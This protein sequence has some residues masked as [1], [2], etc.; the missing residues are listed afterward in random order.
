M[1]EN[2]RVVKKIVAVFDQIKLE[3]KPYYFNIKGRKL[4]VLPDVFS[5]RHFVDSKLFPIEIPKIVKNKSF[6]EIGTG[7]GI[8]ALLCAKNGAKVVATDINPEAIKNCKLN[9]K[10]WK[11]NVDVRKGSVFQPV[12]KDE[13]FDFIFWN[14]PFNY[15]DK[16]PKEMLLNSGLDY[17]YVKLKEY[18]KEGKKFLNP[19]GIL[20]LGTG[21]IAKI[22]FIKK[23]A[24]ANDYKI[25]L[26]RKMTIGSDKRHIGGDL[27]IYALTQKK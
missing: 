12:K 8:V 20:L 14:H 27:R 10:N 1:K 3:K 24:K 13:K 17:H 11:V 4:V 18:I 21:S 19:K 22:S 16:K 2:K 26:I 9:A 5:P 6:L 23:L 7:T 15:V 25:K